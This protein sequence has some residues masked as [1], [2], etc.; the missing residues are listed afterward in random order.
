MLDA[1]IR[2]VLFLYKLPAH[3]IDLYQV[4]TPGQ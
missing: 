2:S 1:A 4:N 3:P